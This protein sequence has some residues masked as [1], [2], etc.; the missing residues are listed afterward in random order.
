MLL[1][2]LAAALHEAGHLAAAFLSGCG[3]RRFSLSPAGAELEMN[4]SL[5]PYKKEIAVYLAGPLGSALGMLISFF[6]L[7]RSFEAHLL[8]FFFC[9]LLFFF[10]NLL[11]VRGLDG[12]QALYALLCLYSER[13]Q[14]EKYL[15][16]LSRFFFILLFIGGILLLAK[17][18]NASLLFF[19]LY[20]IPKGKTKKAT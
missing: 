19:C 8:Y 18:K 13:E 11:P 17:Y 20:L 15:E 6:L 3:I 9:N 12:Y 5:V 14:A 16:T 4:F 7:R 2:L 1:F 10:F